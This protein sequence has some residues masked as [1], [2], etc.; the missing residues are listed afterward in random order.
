MASLEEYRLAAREWL[1]KHLHRVELT[2]SD[3]DPSSERI[4][5][6]AQ[7]QARL[8]EAGYAGF[9]FPVEYGGQGLTFEHERVFMEEAKGYDIPIRFFGVSINISGATLVACG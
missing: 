7:T 2:G 4:A 3:E 6:A 5:E 8:H 9:T 1:A